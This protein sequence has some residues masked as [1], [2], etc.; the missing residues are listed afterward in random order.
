MISLEVIIDNSRND[1]SDDTSDNTSDDVSEIH[2]NDAT[3]DKR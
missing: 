3:D 2:S 1:T